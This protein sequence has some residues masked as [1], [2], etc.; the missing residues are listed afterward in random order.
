MQYIE[1]SQGEKAEFQAGINTVLTRRDLPWLLCEGRMIKVDAEQF[2]SDLK[3]K[4]L[5]LLGKMKNCEPVFQAAYGEF[6][7]ALEYYLKDDYMATISNAE[8]SYESI[9]KVIT[10]N[11]KGNANR[12]TMDY[13]SK[14]CVNLPTSMNVE[15]FRSNVMM[16]LPYVRN[17]SSSD[18]G[19]GAVSVVISK[20][21]A[22]L[23]LNLAASLNTYLIEEYRIAKVSGTSTGQ[24]DVQGEAQDELPF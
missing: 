23:A 7:S 14:Y 1:L 12:L 16:S 8:K 17:N 20:S 4:A 10:G 21:L 9:L 5:E 6:L 3:A 24:E 22:N 2:E 15:G 18:H 13:T 11:A 19:A